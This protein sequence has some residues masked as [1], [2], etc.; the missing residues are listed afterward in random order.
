MLLLLRVV[1]LWSIISVH[2]V[3]GA[4]L[5]RRLFPK[6]SPW[7]GFL[8]PCLALVLLMNFIEHVVAVPTLLWLMPFTVV[9]S[10]W[11][12]FY[13]GLNW[14]SLRWPT[15]IFLVAF[16]FTLAQRALAPGIP[17]LRD[18]VGDLGVMASFCLGDK[19]P[20]PFSWYPALPLSHYYGSAITARRFSL[21]F[22]GP[23]LVPAST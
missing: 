21:V 22:W 16:T 7:F 19:V 17:S 1:F 8:V 10:I 14:K 12:I 15:F 9:G 4:A 13:P 23:T 2:V 6:E 11:A 3:G 5:F 18:G 20:P